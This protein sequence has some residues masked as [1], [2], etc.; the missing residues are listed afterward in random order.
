MRSPSAASKHRFSACQSKTQHQQGLASGLDLS[1]LRIGSACPTPRPLSSLPCSS[2]PFTSLTFG[3]QQPRQQN[4]TTQRAGMSLRI[5][6]Q[7]RQR[8]PGPI[9]PFFAQ[10][11]FPFPRANV[12]ELALIMTSVQV[13]GVQECR[14][15]CCGAPHGLPSPAKQSDDEGTGRR[16]LTSPK[17]RSLLTSNPGHSI[18]SW[19]ACNCNVRDRDIDIVQEPMRSAEAPAEQPGWN[20]SLN[21]VATR[22]PREIARTGCTL[23]LKAQA[24]RLSCEK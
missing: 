4:F 20:L 10:D 8:I 5:C 19:I 18:T 7:S 22:R 24:C 11:I 14:D 6:M 23:L 3:D 17:T 1:E 13:D 9:M 16:A 21:C 12:A 15:V 2:Q